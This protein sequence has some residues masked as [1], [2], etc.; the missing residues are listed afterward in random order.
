MGRAPHSKSHRAKFGRNRGYSEDM[1]LVVEGQGSTWYCLNLP[2][3]FFS[4][5][6]KNTSLKTYHV[7]KSNI[8]RTNLNQKYV[9][10]T[11]TA[12]VNPSKYTDKKEKQKK[13]Q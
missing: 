2:L 4:R 11:Q 6:H 7:S 1:F 12:F 8:S 5:G 3:L 10:N 9:K 13:K